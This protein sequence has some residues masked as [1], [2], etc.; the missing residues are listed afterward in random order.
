[1]L[2]RRSLAALVVAGAAMTC[3]ACSSS[4]SGPPP[5]SVDSGADADAEAGP[6]CAPYFGDPNAP[7]VVELTALK[8]Y[9]TELPLADGDDVTMLFP[10]Q[11]GRVVFVGVR[12]KNVDGCGLQI[13]GAL[14]D[15]TS[16][17]VRLDGRTITLRTDD[18]NFGRSG[19]IPDG[20]VADISSYANIPVCPNQWA[21]TDL[22][23]QSFTLEVSIQDRRGKTA[24]QSLRVVPRCVDS[25]GS[26]VADCRCIC[27]HGYIL[28][29]DCSADGGSDAPLD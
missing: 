6:S 22:F 18:G 8:D 16:K 1:V 20:G 26:S 4:S 3:S 13:T 23:D 29:Q 12:V 24:S 15:P 14:R 21:T 27:A 19:G 9:S 28:G 25:Q 10:P 11:G 2:L 5:P 7:A 17:Q